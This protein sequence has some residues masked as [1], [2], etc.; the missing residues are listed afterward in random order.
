MS[1]SDRKADLRFWDASD[2]FF[3]K[4]SIG[5]R[6]PLPGSMPKPF[7]RGRPRHGIVLPMNDRT[8]PIEA[9]WWRSF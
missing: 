1:S 3:L 4:E 6:K 8:A 7:L 9:L 2:A 5:E